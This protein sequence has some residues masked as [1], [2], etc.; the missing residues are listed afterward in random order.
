[1]KFASLLDTLHSNL[2]RIGKRLAVQCLILE[3]P[4][5][6]VFIDRGDNNRP[7]N[8]AAVYHS[9]AGFDDPF[10]AILCPNGLAEAAVALETPRANALGHRIPS[11]PLSAVEQGGV[12]ELRGAR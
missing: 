4:G 2:L 12:L 10:R 9:R 8:L 1:M 11:N 7:G 3:L 6:R 5:D